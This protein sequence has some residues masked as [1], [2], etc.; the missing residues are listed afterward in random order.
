MT[1]APPTPKPD[2]GHFPGASGA[3]SPALLEKSEVRALRSCLPRRFG[4][5]IIGVLLFGGAADRRAFR[6]M[7]LP[8]NSMAIPTDWTPPIGGGAG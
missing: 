2:P 3:F 1:N 6:W 8:L 4:G 5:L 7:G